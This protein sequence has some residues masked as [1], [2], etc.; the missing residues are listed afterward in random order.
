MLTA[1]EAYR[2]AF[3]F[4]KDRTRAYHPRLSQRRR[5]AATTP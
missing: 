2:S 4:L 1:L 3:T 5:A